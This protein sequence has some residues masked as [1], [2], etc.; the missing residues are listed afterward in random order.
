MERPSWKPDIVLKEPTNKAINLD[1]FIH[2]TH[3]L[4]SK[5]RQLYNRPAIARRL[6]E[7][8]VGFR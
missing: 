3:V 6:S 2:L 4:T 1:I 7:E 8:L 5:L